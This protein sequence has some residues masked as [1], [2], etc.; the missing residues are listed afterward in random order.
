MLLVWHINAVQ[1]ARP[2]LRGSPP[3]WDAGQ[4]TITHE[5]VMRPTTQTGIRSNMT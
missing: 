4:Y 1:A 5:T 3:Q 2:G